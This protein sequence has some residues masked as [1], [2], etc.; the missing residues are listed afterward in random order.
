[1]ISEKQLQDL[2]TLCRI[3][4]SDDFKIEMTCSQGEMA[5]IFKSLEAVPL[6]IAEIRRLKP[7]EPVGRERE[8][9]CDD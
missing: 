4:E 7:F 2:E 3:I 9:W 5:I 8:G 6:L 1:M